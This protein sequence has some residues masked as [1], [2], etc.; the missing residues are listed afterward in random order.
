MAVSKRMRFEVL[1]RDSHTCQYCGESAPNVVLHVDHVKPKALG[2]T[3]GPDNLVTACKD[4]NAGK[5]STILESEHAQEIAK[6]NADWELQNQR[7]A[8]QIRGTVEVDEKY[9]R[10][11]EAQWN[12]GG[13]MANEEPFL[14]H[15][16]RATIMVWSGKGYPWEAMVAA[17]ELAYGKPGVDP[18]RRFNYLCG[19]VWAQIRNAQVELER[20]PAGELH[21]ESDIFKAFSKGWDSG[22]E[23]I[24]YN[25]QSYEAKINPL[26][27]VVDGLENTHTRA[28]VWTPGSEDES[29]G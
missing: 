12:I 20:Q 16:Y 25:F 11:F 6:R 18:E 1:R 15:D 3:D 21:T 13:S 24:F 4:C 2:G 27:L 26:Y 28:M 14:P 5:A 22:Q 9:I 23:D 7:L 19:I 8:A 17:I 10:E 29:V